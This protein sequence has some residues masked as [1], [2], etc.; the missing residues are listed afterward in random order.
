MP[1]CILLPYRCGLGFFL[2]RCVVWSDASAAVW[3]VE[4]LKELRPSISLANQHLGGIPVFR[5]MRE[6]A[7]TL[8]A[9]ADKANV[10]SNQQEQ[11]F[12]ST[13]PRHGS[14]PPTASAHH[15]SSTPETSLATQSLLH[16][17]KRWLM[18]SDETSGHQQLVDSAIQVIGDI[19][20]TWSQS[21]PFRVLA[22]HG[23]PLRMF[24][25][26][27]SMMSKSD[28]FM[29]LE[30]LDSS[31]FLECNFS[32]SS[33]PLLGLSDKPRWPTPTQY[34]GRS[35]AVDGSEQGP[36]PSTWLDRLRKVAALSRVPAQG[37]GTN[38]PT[39]P[40]ATRRGRGDAEPE[41]I[42]RIPPMRI[43]FRVARHTS[44]LADVVSSFFHKFVRSSVGQILGRRFDA[45]ADSMTLAYID[46]PTVELQRRV[47]RHGVRVVANCGAAG[48][49][50][51]AEATL[52][53]YNESVWP[54]VK[55]V[56]AG[57]Q[58]AAVTKSAEQIDM[59]VIISIFSS[60][61]KLNDGKPKLQYSFRCFDAVPGPPT[62]LRV[63][64]E[65]LRPAVPRAYFPVRVC[66]CLA[67]GICN[68]RWLCL[69]WLY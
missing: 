10:A 6:L 60:D 29:D 55:W 65:M 54:A 26:N 67:L 64:C 21:S 61:E 39:M 41:S 15:T 27:D 12:G 59:D 24:D 40:H 19:A 16:G 22:S 44:G 18:L 45:Q 35:E 34:Q 2:S 14:S 53:V 56:V 68:Y 25:W 32:I 1:L 3:L 42:L 28:E 69:Q 23:N 48:T 9:Q 57:A 8:N 7:K 62:M 63:F 31:P 36:S 52:R 38:P 58:R 50:S 13:T 4:G 66:I 46:I 33:I 17:V 30:L 20:R 11:E 5:M 49:S 51:T 37:S 47:D 43:Q